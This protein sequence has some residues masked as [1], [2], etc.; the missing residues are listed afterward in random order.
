MLELDN[1]DAAWL[2][3]RID[4]ELGTIQSIQEDLL[5]SAKEDSTVTEQVYYQAL[6]KRATRLGRIANALEASL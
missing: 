4:Y 3:G 2:M 5:K 1:L 6:N